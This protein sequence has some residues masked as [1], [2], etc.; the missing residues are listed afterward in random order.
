MIAGETLTVTRGATDRFGNRENT[1]THEV[2]GVIA[3]HGFT[4]AT[5]QRAESASGAPELY[6]KAGTDLRARDRI[7]RASGQVFAVVGGPMWDGPHPITG[8]TPKNVAYQLEA[9]T[10]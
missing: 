2:V 1:G 7:T 5:G 6:V 10:G 4:R 3:W 8:N 9:V